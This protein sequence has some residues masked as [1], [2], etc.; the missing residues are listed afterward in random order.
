M[1]LTK[2]QLGRIIQEE[3]S[4]FNEAYYHPAGVATGAKP[5]DPRLAAWQQEKPDWAPGGGE[6]AA[7]EPAPDIDTNQAVSPL[8]KAADELTKAAERAEGSHPHAAEIY[9]KLA[10]L[11]DSYSEILQTPTR[12]LDKD[13]A[14]VLAAIEATATEMVQK[15]Q[16]NLK[17][18][19]D[20]VGTSTG[21]VHPGK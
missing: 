9:E 1:K 5:E 2:Q 10:I 12:D 14:N 11:L 17:R 20:V 18:V 19:A 7:E 6:K 4:K 8:E 16:R 21:W 13:E 15:I 3:I